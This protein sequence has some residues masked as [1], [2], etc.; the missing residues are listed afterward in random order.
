MQISITDLIVFLVYMMA[1]VAFGSSF[2]F[3]NKDADSY[4][5]GA[6]KLPSW[7][8]AMS[9]FAT[10]VS[11]I[12][13]LAIPGKAYASDWNA[14]VFSL[15]IP[16]AAIVAVKF[17][18]PLYRSLSSISA[19]A[20]LEQRF[21]L[22]ASR[23]A[24]ICYILTQLMRTGSILY[25]LV[26][27]VHLMFGWDIATIIVI[28]GVCV[29]FYS[30]LGGIQA[31][32]WTDAIQGIILILGA[33][34]C[35]GLLVFGMPEGPSQ[36]FELAS[37]ANKFSLGSFDFDWKTSTFWVMIIYGLFIN[38]QNYG[39]DQNYVQ[40]YMTAR[41][42]KE[43]K[44]AA[45]FGSLLYVPVSLL[46]FF[47]GS[48]LYAYYQSQPDL[49]PNDLPADQVFPHFIVSQLP[50]GMTGLLIAAIFAAGMSTVSTSINSTA[51]VILNDYFKK[52]NPNLDDKASLK[53]LYAASAIFGVLGIGVALA[54]INVKSALDAWW[55]LA[56]IFS[57]GMLG[58]FLLGYF[59]RRAT[60]FSAAIGVAVGLLVILWMAL[61]PDWFTGSLENLSNP[62]HVNM[63]IVIGTAT[64]FLV[65]FLVAKVVRR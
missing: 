12:S 7:T 51:T 19:Y 64:I 5:S 29:V 4:T 47:I 6:G 49:L 23:Y 13:F 9:I 39:I 65:G 22:W 63:T 24:S 20:Y 17:F 26:L 62:L 31:V 37:K 36:M 57:G 30:M 56:S 16:I 46:F 3:R 60:N 45:L 8:I 34:V 38:L 53:V 27:P 50:T 33:V 44:G 35:V 2:Y 42:E 48:A 52:S 15:S 18:V 25:L 43:A 55:S 41:S 40:R 10:F 32:I 59:A 11:S 54:M 58:L 14:F 1:I 61:S 28:T 21:G